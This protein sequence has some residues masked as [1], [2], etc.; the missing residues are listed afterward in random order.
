MD[1]STSPPPEA[2]PLES[3]L[4]Q[5]DWQG[6]VIRM[7]GL[8]EDEIAAARE[9]KTLAERPGA[10]GSSGSRT[11]SVHKADARMAMGNYLLLQLR[12]MAGLPT[13]QPDTGDDDGQEIA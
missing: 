1:L 2:R 7:A 4:P 5:P 11:A 12:Q 3:E 10:A 6:I 8:I 9:G 13:I